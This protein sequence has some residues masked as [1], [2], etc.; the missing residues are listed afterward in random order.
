MRVPV[1]PQRTDARQQYL[2]YR[3]ILKSGDPVKI[4]K[5]LRD[6]FTWEQMDDLKGKEKE[7]M[8]SARRFIV[9]EISFVTEATKTT[10]QDEVNEALKAMYKKKLTKD[11]E[12]KAKSG[13]KNQPPADPDADIVG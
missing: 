12:K 9:E 3:D 7:L 5:M 10:V 11:R 8:E 13:P 4:T 2:M 1:S 6:L